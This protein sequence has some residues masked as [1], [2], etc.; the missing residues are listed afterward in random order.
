MDY[1][2][3]LEELGEFG[4]WQIT[5]TL[6]VWIPPVV[7]GMMTLTRSTKVVNMFLTLIFS[8][9]YTTLI[10]DAYRCNI[11]DCDDPEN[12]KFD[13]FKPELLFP[14]LAN[15]NGSEPLT[16]PF[17]CNYFKPQR[18]LNNVFTDADNQ[19]CLKV[20]IK[21]SSAFII[22]RNQT[23][24]REVE[25]CGPESTF[26]YADFKMDST[27][28]T[29]FDMVCDQAK[30]VL[31]QVLYKLILEAAHSDLGPDVLL[32]LHA[33]PRPGQPRLRTPLRQDRQETHPAHRRPHH[34]VE[35]ED[36]FRS[37]FN[38][39]SLSSIASVVASQMPGYVSYAILRIIIGA[40]A[41]G[42]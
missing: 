21:V 28:V 4:L 40:G 3:C 8:S 27:L 37:L 29:D 26:A 20:T 22:T 33:G 16:H 10:P 38:I 5:V 15:L 17:Y 2:A 42:W 18:D 24:T 31:D 9:S 41:E 36:T 30:E 13:D 35:V 7:D 11:P 12:F 32:L 14:S 23:M 34:Q 39:L 6:L 1:D 25:S 19:T